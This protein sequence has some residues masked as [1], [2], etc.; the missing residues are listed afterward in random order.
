MYNPKPNPADFISVFVED[1]K[2][3]GNNLAAAAENYEKASSATDGP[4][5]VEYLYLAGVNY[6]NA[7]DTEKGR[8]ALQKLID[9]HPDSPKAYDA[10]TKLILASKE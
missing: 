1:N 10:K 3:L 5:V 4:Q 6:L 9:E 8:E 7:G 2:D